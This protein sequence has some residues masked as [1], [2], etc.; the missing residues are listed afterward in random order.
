VSVIAVITK[1]RKA[2]KLSLLVRDECEKLFLQGVFKQTIR[3][4]TQIRK[5][6][7]AY[8]SIFE[9]DKRVDVAKDYKALTEELI[10]ECNK[11]V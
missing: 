10:N 7:A 6:S 8:R 5:S 11:N 3:E 4:T 9:Y 1:F 2:N